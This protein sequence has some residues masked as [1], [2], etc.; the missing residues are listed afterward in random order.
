MNDQTVE[1]WLTALASKSSTPGGGAAAAVNA[2]IGAALVSMVCNLTIGKPKYAEH[3]L[4]MVDVRSRAEELRTRLVGL[5]AEDATAFDAVM[6]AYGLPKTT[7][8]EKAA[9]KAAVQDALHGA[10]DVPMRIAATAADVIALAGR[11]LDGANVNVLSDVAVAVDSA[12][13][14][15]RSAILNVEVN[16]AAIT[17]EGHRAELAAGI[18]RYQD[19]LLTAGAISEHVATRIR[20]S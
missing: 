18:A 12:G 10:A 14:A 2:A 17:D 6:A 4:T 8:E 20:G 5:A 15:L 3:E 11:I 1:D 16:R 13:A 7:D 9:R 19:A